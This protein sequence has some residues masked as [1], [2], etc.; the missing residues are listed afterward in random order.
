M[1]QH[2]ATDDLLLEYAAGGLDEGSSLLVASHLALCDRCRQVVADAEALGG[3]LLESTP[4]E[5]LAD[6]ATAAVL[7]R[8]DGP[9]TPRPRVRVAGDDRLPVPVRR[10]TA[11]AGAHWRLM[12]RGVRQLVLHRS[13]RSTARL[14]RLAPGSRVPEH[15]H[16]G[17]ELTLVLTGAY[18]DA[19][20]TFARGD[21][22]EH[23]ESVMH[24]PAVTDEAECIVLA[25]T[26]APL[27]F[28][29]P[30]VRLVQPL[31]GV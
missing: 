26:D 14:I 22:A 27:H 9:P 10:Y 25:V 7:A 4:A 19:F 8:L 18:R 30:L 21:V 15:T 28:R 6:S 20:G 1:I 13:A 2:H 23:D 29:S 16:G 11:E 12:G 3:A 31:L 24:Q 17:R 5:L